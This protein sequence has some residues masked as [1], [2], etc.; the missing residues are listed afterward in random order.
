MK[1]KVVFLKTPKQ[2]IQRL[3]P[4]PLE[5]LAQEVVA[6]VNRGSTL[7]KA[8]RAYV[9]ANALLLYRNDQDWK[10][11]L[12]SVGEAGYL[13]WEDIGELESAIDDWIAGEA[14]DGD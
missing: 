7:T 13:D 5:F 14:P 1:T 6:H 9:L 11:Y 8:D 4:Y 3:S 10:A 12:N 2:T